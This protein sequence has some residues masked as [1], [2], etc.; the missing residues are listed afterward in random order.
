[1]RWSSVTHRHPRSQLACAYCCLLAQRLMQGASPESAHRETS[2]AFDGILLNY[3]AERGNFERVLDD[4][5]GLSRREEIRSGGYVIDTL[6]AAVWCLLQGGGFHDI[7]LRAVNLGGDTDTTG[8]VAG[9]LAG[10]W[11]GTNSIPPHWRTVLAA[12]PSVTA[13]IVRF[14]ENGSAA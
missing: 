12:E 8:C 9:G 6:E 4:D 10:T 11:L 7:V 13:L 3:P 5:F 14:A 1:M 2:V